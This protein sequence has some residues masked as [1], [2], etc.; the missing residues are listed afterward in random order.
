M[1][2]VSQARKIEAVCR[3]RGIQ[4]VLHFTRACNLPR[5]MKRGLLT[6]DQLEQLTCED[7]TFRV[8][9]NDELRLDE[10]KNSLSFS[11]SFPNSPLF[12][13]CRENK[14][15]GAWSVLKLD[16]SVLWE[17][18]CAF[19]PGNA[20]GSKLQGKH[21]EL[22]TATSLEALFGGSAGERSGLPKWI[23]TNVQAEVLVYASLPP[24]RIQ[25]VY[26]ESQ[27]HLATALECCDGLIGVQRFEV[28]PLWFSSRDYAL[29]RLLA[30]RPEAPWPG[31]LS[32]FLLPL[33]RWFGKFKSTLSGTQA[34][35]G[36]RR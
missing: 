1:S 9:L 33:A 2:T 22:T 6:R 30:R 5:I 12:Y 13:S 3:R 24:D 36:R 15:Q 4:E 8:A 18:P 20:A 27:K 35:R 25:A 11:V 14:Y 19:C 17:F 31:A 34:S 16:A 10:Q 7:P 32:S 26:F 23:P 21:S 29:K 28:D